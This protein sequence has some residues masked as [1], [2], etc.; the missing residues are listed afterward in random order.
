VGHRRTD[1]IHEEVVIRIELQCPLKT[2]DGSF[3]VP[4]D[5]V[6]DC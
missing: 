1:L 4:L 5:E 6:E 3:V 2:A